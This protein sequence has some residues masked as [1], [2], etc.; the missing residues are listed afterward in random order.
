MVWRDLQKEEDELHRLHR[1]LL[2]AKLNVDEKFDII[3]MNLIFIEMTLEKDVNDMC[4][5]SQE[6]KEQAYAGRGG[7]WHCEGVAKTIIKMYRKEGC[8]AE[9]ISDLL[10]HGS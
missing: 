6:I 4:N 10:S 1:A 8:G 5:L 2:S 7:K 3:E 9:Q